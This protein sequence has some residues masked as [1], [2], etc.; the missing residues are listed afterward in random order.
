M[1]LFIEL[2]VSVP[3]VALDKGV[4]K[5]KGMSEAQTFSDLTSKD[6]KCVLSNTHIG[7]D[8]ERFDV[9]NR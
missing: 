4:S 5:M 6:S 2:A 1:C 3:E 8:R 7:F 9:I